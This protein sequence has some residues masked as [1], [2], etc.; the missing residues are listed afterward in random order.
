MNG[1]CLYPLTPCISSSHLT[2]HRVYGVSSLL[3]VESGGLGCAFILDR[4]DPYVSSPPP[5]IKKRSRSTT[6]VDQIAN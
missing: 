6:F 3:L 2:N 4:Y 5:L 1:G